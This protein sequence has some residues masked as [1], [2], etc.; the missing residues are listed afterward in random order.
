MPDDR[1]FR[2]AIIDRV[3]K[4]DLPIRKPPAIGRVNTFAR[5][6]KSWTTPGSWI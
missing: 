3:A 5:A 1:Q 4:F 2:Q 6:E